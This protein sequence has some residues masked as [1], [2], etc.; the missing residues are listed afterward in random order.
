M[1]IGTIKQGISE[2]ITQEQVP[3]GYHEA[4]RGYFDSLEIEPDGSSPE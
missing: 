2:A 1:L 3:P 4:I